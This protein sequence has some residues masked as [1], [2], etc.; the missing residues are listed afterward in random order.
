V[1]L[2]FTACLAALGLGQSAPEYQTGTVTRPDG[3][4]IAYYVRPGSG[5][6]LVLIPGSWGDYRVFDRLVA[7][8]SPSLRVVIVELRGHGRSRPAT[9]NAT[10]EGFADDVLSVA[11]ALVLRRFYVGGHSIGGML[12][13]EIAGRR[14]GQVA[15][16]IAMEGWTHHQVA[17][18]AFGGN[19]ANTLTPEQEKVNAENRQ[20]VR[21]RLT[22]AEIDAFT[23]V[24]RRWDG[25]PILEST[26]TPILE[27]WGDRGRPRPSRELMRIPLRPNIELVWMPGAS[28]SLLIQCPEEVARATNAFIARTE[29]APRTPK[30][31]PALQR[32]GAAST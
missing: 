14:P 17:A 3:S 13:I 29:S 1:R 7:G 16:A 28:H 32:G 26:A 11:D 15:G 12:A 24:W 22:Q 5:P 4:Q 25:F 19:A 30:R 23:S 18:E 6:S 8:L 20:R 9:L 2:V 21:S 31:N 10:M 27:I